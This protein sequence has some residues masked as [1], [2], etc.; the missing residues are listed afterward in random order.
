MPLE[1]LS[2]LAP[3]ARDAR[4]AALRQAEVETPIDLVA[5]PVARARL[6]RLD[7]QAHE[8]L[9]TVHHIV[10]DGWSIGVLMKEI[11]AVY[12]ARRQGRRPGAAAGAEPGRLRRRREGVAAG[13][14]GQGARGLLGRALPGRGAGDGP[15]DRPAAAGG[16]DRQRGARRQPDGSAAR[17]PAARRRQ[18][19]GQHAAEPG[20]GGL[21][22]LPRPRHRRARHRRRPALLG[23]ALLRHGERGRPLR[24]LP[25][26]PQPHRRRPE[27]QGVPRRHAPD[28]GRCAR[29]PEL[30]LRQPDQGAA[31]AARPVA[32][33][34]WC[35]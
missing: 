7:A 28:A 13:P 23:P 3:A 18:G 17:G 34:R 21:P 22:A 33:A 6:L 14:R 24:E 9:I 10:C 35:R 32:G 12:E 4:L 20:A 31:P 11:N 19:R 15:S 25:A 1:D 27:L 26:D 2:T 8:L 29:P 16:Q 30:H 5:G